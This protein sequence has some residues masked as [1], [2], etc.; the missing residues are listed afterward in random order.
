MPTTEP[1]D[2]GD[3]VGGPLNSIAEFH[4]AQPANPAPAPRPA[5]AAAAAPASPAPQSA[6]RTEV[7]RAPA[8]TPTPVPAG[9]PRPVVYGPVVGRPQARGTRTS[10]DSKV[11]S[12]NTA[13][14]APTAP[15]ADARSAE[16]APR[17]TDKPASEF[18]AERLTRAWTSYIESHGQEQLLVHTMRSHIPVRR[19]G[20]FA[21][22]V[23]VD[24]DMQASQINEAMPR[25]L[26]HLHT[27]LDNYS[28]TI[29]VRVK[30][31]PGSPSTWNEREVLADML[32][33]H[34]DLRRYMDELGLTLS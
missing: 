24:S 11:L 2:D 7:H 1:L 26:D 30:D 29:A 32:K 15:S 34:P 13:K 17:D 12:I 33:R 6:V 25:L 5:P 27:S 10:L 20:S 28:V 22:D 19:A 23:E 31:G 18:T 14:A 16:T 3:D 9:G 8:P 21:L 4:Q